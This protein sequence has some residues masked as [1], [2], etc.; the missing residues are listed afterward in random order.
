L[1]RLAVKRGDVVLMVAGGDFGK[2]RPGV[3]V[4]ADELGDSTT[5]VLV[6]PLS[7]DIQE[8]PRL[9]PAVEPSSDN[10][11][12]LHSQIMTE[13]VMP[14]RRDRV[15]RVIGRLDSDAVSRL[16]RALLVVLGLA[17]V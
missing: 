12:R 2:P 1:E 11:L 14:I 3:V 4:Q 6:C 16:D 8:S 7:S 17:Y 5:T 13:K 10:G 15:R 9:R